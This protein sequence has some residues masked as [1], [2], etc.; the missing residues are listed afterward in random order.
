IILGDVKWTTT[1]SAETF[2]EFSFDIAE[3]LK[4]ADRGIA[5]ILVYETA[6]AGGY[7]KNPK[8]EV[9]WTTDATY[10]ITFTETNG[11][12]ATVTMDGKD[13]T[14]GISLA[15]G[16][17]SYTATATGY[18]DYKGEFTVAGANLNVEFTMSPKASWNYT[19][20]NNVNDEVKTG[21]C[22]EGLS[23]TVPYSRYILASDGTVWMKDATNKEY[24]YTFTPD[25]DNYETTLEY[26]ATEITDGIYFVEGEDI[27]GMTVA[28]GSNA[29]IRCSNSAGG[30]AEEAVEVYTLKP[31][32]Y[33][34]RMG[35]WGNDGETFTVKA[36][37]ETV[38]SA[39]TKGWWFEEVGT[40]FTLTAETALTFEGATSSRPLDYILIT[41]TV[42][43]G[44]SAV[45]AVEAANADGKWYNLQG[46]QI[47]APTQA[48]LYIHNGKKVI[49]K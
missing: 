2:E 40:E 6:A 29:N 3:A 34:V 24:N 1:K 32:T 44:G 39:A 48:G 41:G 47:A 17:Y 36:G 31:G 4:K 28:T 37:E 13:V 10:D 9:E 18:Q 11:I 38:C 30:F 35:V 23:A 20:K 45:N 12:A 49:V 42:N 22:L 7:I 14:K 5:T 33:V 15:D 21:T 16:T 8:V 26:S 46:V 43:G 25:V 19:V 27:K